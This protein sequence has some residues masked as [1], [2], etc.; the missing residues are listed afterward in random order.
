MRVLD[1]KSPF[2][3]AESEFGAPTEWL[4]SVRHS[5]PREGGRPGEGD[6]DEREPNAGLA[7]ATF[8]LTPALSLEEREQHLPPQYN[9]SRLGGYDFI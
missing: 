9:S 3:L 1:F 4:R 2:P 8:P 5:V 7:K 6:S